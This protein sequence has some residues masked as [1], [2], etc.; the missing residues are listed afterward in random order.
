M[1][2]K[3]TTQPTSNEE[4]R[5]FPMS[6]CMNMSIIKHFSIVGN[7]SVCHANFLLRQ[8][9]LVVFIKA[10]TLTEYQWVQHVIFF[11]SV[12]ISGNIKLYPPPTNRTLG[13]TL[14]FPYSLWSFSPCICTRRSLDPERCN[15][16]S[17]WPAQLWGIPVQ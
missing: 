6:H 16:H 11:S 12:C 2:S 4:M 7:K 17:H 13:E 3:G 9:N 8:V 14:P 1:P 10:Q 15:F 5:D